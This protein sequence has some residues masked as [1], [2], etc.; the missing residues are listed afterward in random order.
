MKLRQFLKLRELRRRILEHI[1]DIDHQRDTSVARHMTMAHA[2]YP[3]S[4]LFW[5][6]EVVKMGERRG[7]LNRRLTKRN[8]MD[9]PFKIPTW[10]E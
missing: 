5:I 7:D 3:F 1:G 4:I 2:N 8:G 10:T 9:F 6:L